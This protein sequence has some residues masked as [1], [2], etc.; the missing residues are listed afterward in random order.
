MGS[1]TTF[2]G[3]GGGGS[4][5]ILFVSLGGLLA[6]IKLCVWSI[7]SLIMVVAL[8]IYSA[9]LFEWRPFSPDDNR[10]IDRRLSSLRLFL[11]LKRTGHGEWHVA[12]HRL[13]NHGAESCKTPDS[14]RC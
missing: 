14:R 10:Y 12:V 6:S 8:S 11:R 4:N 2:R 13:L 1:L 3:D 5:Q 7:Y 9:V